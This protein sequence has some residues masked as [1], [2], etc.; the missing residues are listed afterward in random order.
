MTER[1][2]LVLAGGFWGT[3]KE[4]LNGHQVDVEN[5][6][7]G[8]C[9]YLISVTGLPNDMFRPES[10]NRHRTYECD[11]CK[12]P[13]SESEMEWKTGCF[14][15]R[16]SFKEVAID[17]WRTDVFEKYDPLK[18]KWVRP[19]FRI[20][21]NNEQGKEKFREIWRYVNANFPSNKLTPVPVVV[22]TLRDWTL[23]EEEVPHIELSIPEE[24]KVQDIKEKDVI[25]KVEGCGYEAK[26]ARALRM[27]T[28]MKHKKEVKY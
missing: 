8:M 23:E 20:W 22:G 26:S 19:G 25:C 13:I 12:R 28:S 18:V 5:S 11:Q 16:K 1:R 10:I 4:L 21:V 15:H 17:K 2:Y 7:V 3:S 14:A 27:H 24:L 6:A 9:D